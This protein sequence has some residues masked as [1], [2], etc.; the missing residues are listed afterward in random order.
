M[1]EVRRDLDDDVQEI[2]NGV[3]DLVE[4]RTYVKRYPWVVLGSAFV[5]GYA[6][7]PRSRK[8]WIA[9]HGAAESLTGF[10]PVVSESLQPQHRV[11]DAALSFIGNLLLRGTL[12]FVS[13]Q[14]E[15]IL[16]NYAEKSREKE[17]Q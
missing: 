6:I 14:T 9:S 4:W 13:I 11:R 5:L 15:K 12:N 16:A 2:S 17:S 7:V 3:R 1:L 8:R 10:Q